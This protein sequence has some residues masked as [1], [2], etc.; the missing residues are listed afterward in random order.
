MP[1]RKTVQK[2]GKGVR[3][4]T[5]NDDGYVIVMGNEIQRCD[6]C[7]K[8]AGDLEAAKAFFAENPQYFLDRILIRQSEI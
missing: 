3:C 4:L 8:Y 5:C 1:K 7:S 6:G 2:I